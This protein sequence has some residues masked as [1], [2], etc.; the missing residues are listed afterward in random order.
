MGQSFQMVTLL[1][2]TSPLR[3]SEDIRNTYRLF[4]EKHARSVISVCEAEHSPV[5]MKPLGSGYSMQG[6][7]R[8]NQNVRRQEQET[9]YR[10]NGAIYMMDRYVL[11]DIQEL[12]GK[13]SYAYIMPRERSVDID[14]EEDFC[15][16][17]F[18][19][20]YGAGE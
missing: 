10:L 20:G 7:I 4:Q 8:L 3:M 6:F 1:Q 2:P 15:Y 11:D 14:T 13:R 12:Y 16:A 17:E 9:Y 5:F 18:L 19:M